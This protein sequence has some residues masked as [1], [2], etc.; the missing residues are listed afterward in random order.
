MNIL[1]NLPKYLVL[2]VL[3]GGVFIIVGKI[4]SSGSKP[5]RLNVSIPTLSAEAQ[6]G[7]KLFE[8]NCM[9]CHGKN[10]AGTE[11]GPPFI[12]NIYRSNHH[13]DQAFV[14]AA[15]RGVRSHHWRFGN[16]PPQPQVT[17]YEVLKIVRYVRE[18]Q[19][20]NGIR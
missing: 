6:E 15:M 19:R 1:S 11:Q 4:T 9:A 10:A 5:G 7:K 18:L 20:A 14:L 3:A 2:A 13:A 17:S 16:M 8:A 12:N